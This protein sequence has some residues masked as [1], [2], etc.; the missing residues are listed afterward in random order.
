MEL[1][2]YSDESGVFD[3]VHNDYY[4]YGGLILVNNNLS[5]DDKEN[6]FIKTFP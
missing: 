3:S 4:V 1:F 6:I 2:I 5:V